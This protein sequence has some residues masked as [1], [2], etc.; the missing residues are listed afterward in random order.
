MVWAGSERVAFGVKSPWVVAWYCAKGN[1]PAVGQSGSPAA[2]K[3]NVKETCIENGMNVCYNQA[4]LLAHNTKRA[5]HQDTGP[6]SIYVEAAAAIQAEMDATTFAGVMP[7]ASDR[8]EKF[9]DCAESIFTETD[10]EKEAEV[11]LG[12][13]ATNT[14]YDQGNALINWATG[15]PTLQNTLNQAKVDKL[16]YIIWKT[17]RKVGFGIKGKWVVAWYCDVRPLTALA[18]VA[19]DNIESSPLWTPDGTRR[20][21]S[22][23]RRLAAADYSASNANDGNADTYTLTKKGIGMFWQGA[24]KTQPM[25]VSQVKLTNAKAPADA[26]R[27]TLYRVLIDD[28]PCGITAASVANGKVE[29][30][31]CGTAPNYISGSKVRV[32]T[33]TMTN[34]QLAEVEVIGTDDSEESK[35]QALKNNAGQP[36]TSQGYNSCYNALALGKHNDYREGHEFTS[37]SSSATIPAAISITPALTLDVDMAKKIQKMLKDKALTTTDKATVAASIKSS[38]PAGCTANIYVETN[39]AK[40]AGLEK[41]NVATDAWYTG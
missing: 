22:E 20:R 33:T 8:R 36:C 40:I 38:I 32:E 4:A 15:R 6:L 41:S 21:L 12:K 2:Y 16:L 30:V 19:V 7:A 17:T 28:K 9:Q 29:V 25:K 3:E 35:D 11:A 18:Q 27:F 31:T 34:L 14:W 39:N 37:T 13:V 24:L 23:H 5:L 1:E 10:P 26:S